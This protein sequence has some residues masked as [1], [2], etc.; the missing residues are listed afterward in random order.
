M[1]GVIE[2]FKKRRKLAWTVGIATSGYL[3]VQYAKSKFS[4]MQDRII[5][6]RAAQDKSVLSLAS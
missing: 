3:L 2:Y 1:S 4:E 6:S 5:E